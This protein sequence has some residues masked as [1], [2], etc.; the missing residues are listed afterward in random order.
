MGDLDIFRGHIGVGDWELGSGVVNSVQD[1]GSMWMERLGLLTS[2]V[3][4]HE[5]TSQELLG[6]QV[7]GSNQVHGNQDAGVG[8]D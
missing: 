3:N 2:C 7:V 4:G 6:F 8:V 1:S 5:L